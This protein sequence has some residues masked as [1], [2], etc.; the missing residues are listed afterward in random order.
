MTEKQKLTN[1]RTKKSRN[2]VD[3]ESKHQPNAKRSIQK[4]GIEKIKSKTP[5][6]ELNIVIKSKYKPATQIKTETH[7]NKQTNKSKS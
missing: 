4:P 7:L 5:R 3:P 6:R 1:P 2:Y